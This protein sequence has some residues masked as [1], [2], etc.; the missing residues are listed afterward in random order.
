MCIRDRDL[1]A[2]TRQIQAR[3]REDVIGVGVIRPDG[4][5]PAT[6]AG[7]PVV[8]TLE[9]AVRLLKEAGYQ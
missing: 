4:Y 7:W 6:V 3:L 2:I 8:M 9:Q 5:G 1:N